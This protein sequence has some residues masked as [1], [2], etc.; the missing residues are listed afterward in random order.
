M[1]HPCASDVQEGVHLRHV[2][3]KPALNVEDGLDARAPH[4]VL[5]PQHGQLDVAADLGPQHPADGDLRAH[6]E[7]VGPDGGHPPIPSAAGKVDTNG[8]L[9]KLP[10]GQAVVRALD[11]EPKRRATGEIEVFAGVASRTETESK[12]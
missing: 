12:R 5:R 6:I 3:L 1:A 11:L 7:A 9:W 2:D 8:R 4:G 10:R